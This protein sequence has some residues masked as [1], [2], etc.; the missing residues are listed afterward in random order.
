MSFQDDMSDFEQQ[1]AQ[2]HD[3]IARSVTIELFSSIVKST[4]VKT[5]RARGNWQTSVDSPK[6]GEIDRDDRGGTSAITEVVSETPPG[7]GQE[8]F[9]TNNL[10]YIDSLEN[11]SSQQAPAGMV[12]KNFARII[13]I[14]NQAVANFRV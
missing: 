4:P 10:P 1:V 6:A 13:R 2:A 5:G 7:M 14:L 8:T 12:R 11:G 9:L 3:K